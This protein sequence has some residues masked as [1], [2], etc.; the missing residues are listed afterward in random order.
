MYSEIREVEIYSFFIAGHPQWDGTQQPM[1][2]SQV[3]NEQNF[4]QNTTSS[5]QDTVGYNQTSVNQKPSQEYQKTKNDVIIFM[6][7]FLI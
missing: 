6:N 7:I 3:P 1:P 5:Y 4:V 2:Q